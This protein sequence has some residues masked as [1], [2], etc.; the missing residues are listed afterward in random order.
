MRA[1][2][3]PGVVPADRDAAGV[4]GGRPRLVQEPCPSPPA[5][6]CSHSAREHYNIHNYQRKSSRFLGA[7][8]HL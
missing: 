5:L 7:E 3:G 8:R 1:S 6:R 2:V 4:G